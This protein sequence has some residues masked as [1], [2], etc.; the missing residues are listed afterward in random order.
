MTWKHT[1]D[2]TPKMPRLVRSLGPRVRDGEHERKNVHTKEKLRSRVRKD[3]QR[4]EVRKTNQERPEGRRKLNAKV[5][6]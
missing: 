2:S 5:S 4:K 3:E 6:N 1:A